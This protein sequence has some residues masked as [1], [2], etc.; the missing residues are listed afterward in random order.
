MYARHRQ[1][2]AEFP[3]AHGLRFNEGLI[4]ADRRK[5]SLQATS[6]SP[7]ESLDRDLEASWQPCMS[8]AAVLNLLKYRVNAD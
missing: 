3:E 4:P 1:Q 8:A 2:F 5:K 7:T 6:I